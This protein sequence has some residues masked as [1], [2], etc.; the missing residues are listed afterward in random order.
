MSEFTIVTDSGCDIDYEQL[1]EYG[2]PCVDL[3]FYAEGSDKEFTNKDVPIHAFDQMMR[4]GKVFKTSMASPD[5]FRDAFKAEL[6]KGNDVLYIGFSS[7]LSSTVGSARIAAEDMQEAYP[8]KKII[9]IDSLCASAGQG[10][11]VYLAYQKK[12]EGATLE[13]VAEYTEKTL[14]NLCHWFTVDDLVYLKRGGRVSSA[15]AL[16]GTILGIRPVLHVSDDGHLVNVTKARGRKL[17]VKALA[18]HLKDSII[19]LEGA[20]YFISHADCIKDAHALEEMIEIETGTKA[21]C[22]TN[23][24]PIIGAHSGPGTLALFFVGKQR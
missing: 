9:V 12:Q 24:S 21:T 14:P 4:S 2:I 15:V 23:I 22:I 13:E 6:E 17:A 3:T 8:D 20:T 16:A 7:G 11:L 18:D 10:L 19:D 5:A 1:A